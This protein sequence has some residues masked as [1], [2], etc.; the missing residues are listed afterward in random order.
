MPPAT[1]EQQDRPAE[2]ELKQQEEQQQQGAV[3]NPSLPHV[4]PSHLTQALGSVKARTA[5][6]MGAPQVPNVAW[7]DVGGLEDVKQAILDTVE[8]PLKHR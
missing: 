4:T 5:T 1:A 6:E 7:E 3:K 8:L 2:C